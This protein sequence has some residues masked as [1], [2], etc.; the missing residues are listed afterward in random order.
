MRSWKSDCLV[1][2]CLMTFS[3]VTAKA[4][5]SM[6]A[7]LRRPAA[8]Q[9]SGDERFLF[10]AN[11]RSGSLSTLDLQSGAISAE[12]ELGRCL[13]AIRLTGD[14]R[15]LL[16]A[17]EHSHE[18]VLCDIRDGSVT[19][20][21][22]LPVTPYPVDIAI[23]RDGRR[24]FV[25]SLWSQ[26]VSAVELPPARTS[27]ASVSG[28][29]VISVL[30][31]PFAP[32]CLLLVKDESRL[33]VADAFG[34]KLAV[35]DPSSMQMQHVRSFPSH[36]I[37]G[38]A[39]SPD[40][41]KLLVA[42][43][44]LNELAH[45]TNND[46]HWGLLMS[47]DL[48]WL[49][50]DSVLAPAAD[51]YTG[52]HMHP[53]GHAGNATADPSGI[54]V[55]PNGT[56]VVTMGGIDEMAVG[57]E[58]DYSLDRI[59]LGR[60]PTAVTVSRDGRR[61]FVAN[62]F[63]D[64]ISIVDLKNREATKEISLGPQPELSLVDRGELLFYDARLSHDG[65]MSCHSCHTDGHTNG[66]LND[67]F[68]D[69]SFGA[70]KRVLSLAGQSDTAPFAWN[71]RVASL[72]DQVRNSVVQTMQGDEPPTDRQVA[73]L[74]AYVKSLPLPPS[75]A[76]ARASG[77]AGSIKRG[78][79]LFGTL[80]CDRCHAPPTY[81]TPQVY[82]VGLHDKQGNK[83]FNPP[84][85]RS[86]SQRGPYFHDNRAESLSA[87]FCD[88]GHQLDRELAESELRDLVAFLTSL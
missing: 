73:A 31:L 53:L 20:R 12:V 29:K 24:A 58:N 32:R 57:V 6:S 70:P 61:A 67:N 26:R 11:R 9:L 33:I 60:R 87:V 35:I 84:S 71:A 75:L 50:V 86:V 40:G 64:S 51:L 10:V 17:D 42:H 74:V 34:G 41:R 30:D 39:T 38:L 5:T 28:M 80:K 79:Q 68:S 82:D 59:G 54:A 63:A 78:H 72:D 27:E 16:A 14:G 46:V 1:A 76:A 43:Q 69:N 4:E 62:T 8:V 2:V 48:R 3:A 56:V 21:Q 45:T 19:V 88:F 66:L 37:R 15:S 47:N 52:A 7:R 55:A 23:A 22:R 13:S 49:Q 83:E 18:L 25:T 44:M 65:W 85:L 81:T 36:N 77:D